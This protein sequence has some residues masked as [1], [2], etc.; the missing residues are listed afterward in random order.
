[1]VDSIVHSI[2]LLTPFLAFASSCCAQPLDASA[3][4]AL[5]RIATFTTFDAPGAVL[6]AYLG[7]YPTSINITG[8]I[9]GSYSDMNF[10]IRGFVRSPGGTMTSFD[11]PATGTDPSSMNAA[12]SIAGSYL[13]GVY[14]VFHGF[15]RAPGGTMTTFD[16]P[17][18]LLCN[19]QGTFASS[20]NTGGLVAGYYSYGPTCA[21]SGFIRGDSGL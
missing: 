20:I 2:R 9:T 1:M 12:G 19:A 16:A 15:V 10:V 17:G 7:T 21:Y 3:T 14:G 18:V 8:A 6:G 13:A 5:P 4:V 11:A